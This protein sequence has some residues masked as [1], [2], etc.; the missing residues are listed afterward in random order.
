[1]SRLRR[2]KTK[3]SRKT[4]SLLSHSLTRSHHSLRWHQIRSVRRC[5]CART[6][7][8]PFAIHCLHICAREQT[9]KMKMKKQNWKWKRAPLLSCTFQH[10]PAHSLLYFHK[11]SSRLN[12]NLAAEYIIIIICIL[13]GASCRVCRQ[14]ACMR[15]STHFN[16]NIILLDMLLLNITRNIKCT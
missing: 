3:T 15:R 6:F 16:N 4:N 10:S 5:I 1:M 14:H 2:A 7:I 9:P 8:H 11:F 12:Y 13:C